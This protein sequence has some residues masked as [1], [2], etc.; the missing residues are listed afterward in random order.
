MPTL[1]NVQ[2]SSLVPN[3]DQALEIAFGAISRKRAR[4]EAEVVKQEQIE[5][6][7]NIDRQI[8]VLTSGSQD[9]QEEEAAL[10]RLG[11]IDPA[12]ANVTRAT[13]E[14]GNQQELEALRQTAEQ[15][16][17]DSVFVSTQPD[18]ASKQAAI[19]QLASQAAVRGEPL[20]RFIQLQNM[21]EPELDLELQ[22]MQIAAQDI[23]TLLKPVEA[24]K[25]TTAS[26]K[27]RQDL[28]AGLITQAEFDAIKA[29]PPE[30]Q[31]EVGKLLGDRQLAVSMGE[32]SGPAVA[33]IDATLQSL[34]NGKPVTP[35]FE[36]FTDVDGNVFDVDINSPD[37]AQLAAETVEAGGRA[38]G[39]SDPKI[40]AAERK[41]AGFAVRLDSSSLILN[42]LQEEFSGFG[43]GVGEFL[44]NFAKSADRQRFDQAS[45]NFINAVLRNESGAAIAP[46]EFVSA[47]KQY[48]PQ[49]GDS[50]AVLEQKKAN[51]DL[52][53]SSFRA[54]SG[55]ALAPTVIPTAP[56]LSAPQEGATAT[57]PTTGAVL[58]FRN[59]QWQTP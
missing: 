3:L 29:T 51:R 44:P 54:A 24:I 2:G 38:G 32:G 10:L 39:T 15:G 33:A 56:A 50:A 31:T 48:I 42:E 55:G 21:S 45:R 17:R 7:A 5:R 22:R 8:N 47:E 4:D 11:A 41:A 18:F 52:V 6:Q 49:P 20:D 46:S 28:D 1:A 30:F 53:A 27:A 14:S 37:G 35:K 58:V 59:G 40:T 19:G 34:I 12:L 9:P 43:A 13:I 26:G 23:G 25:P 57:N 36:T 16:A